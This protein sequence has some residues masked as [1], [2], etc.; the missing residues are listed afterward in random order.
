MTL[1]FGIVT[2]HDLVDR[3]NFL[4]RAEGKLPVP[5]GSFPGNAAGLRFIVKELRL[6]LARAKREGAP[7]D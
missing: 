2:A 7:S 6:A 4:W 5:Q 1:V 3:L